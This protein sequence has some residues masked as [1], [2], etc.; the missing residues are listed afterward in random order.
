LE[1]KV[2]DALSRQPEPL[3]LQAISSSTPKWLEIIIE[4]YTKDHDAKQLLTEL[5]LTGSSDK[6][7]TLTDASSNIRTEFGWEIILKHIKL[8]F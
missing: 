4:G 8:F 3:Q 6:G 1:N 5:S 2:A 7:F